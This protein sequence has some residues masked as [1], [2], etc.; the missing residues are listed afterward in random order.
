M[1]EDCADKLRGVL[2]DARNSGAREKNISINHPK[3][4]IYIKCDE[5]SLMRAVMNIT[6]NCIRYAKTAVI[7]D[8][9]E[10][11]GKIIINIKDDGA[12]IDEQE[13]PDIFKRFYKGKS[14]K[15]GI[16]L[17]IAKAIIEQHGAQI[18][19]GNRK[20]CSGAEFIIEFDKKTINKGAS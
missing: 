19:A 1:L 12:G 11:D 5:E 3:R 10:N 7:I 20:D 6:A 17:S 15:H 18:Y 8:Y 4:D 16:G 14:G 13:L 2:I 9:C